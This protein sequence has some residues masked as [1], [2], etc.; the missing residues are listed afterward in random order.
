MANSS[1]SKS[2]IFTPVS[3]ANGGTG[4]TTLT[5]ILKGNGTSAFTAVTA[6]SGNIVGD[7]D[8]Q[9][10]T[11]K[12]ISLGSNTIYGT[13]SQFNSALSD[14]DFAT[15]AGTETLSG[16]TLVSPKIANNGSI[17]DENGNEQ[18][19]F[20]TTASA[21][22]ELTIKNAS[23]GQAPE[24]QATGNDTN[25]DLKL[26]PKGSGKI[27]PNN[28]VNFGAFTAYFTET[29][30]GN[31]GTAKTIDWTL[32]N[33]QKITLTGNCTFTFTNPPGPCSL[34]FKLAQDATG[35]RTVTWPSAVKWSGGTAPTL[36]T[37]ANKVDIISFYYDGSSYFGTYSL[38]YT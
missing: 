27:V 29:N 15:L 33:K 14:G 17:N 38:N 4:A 16:K 7:T 5:G 36:T 28:N 12:T 10:L 6:P 23:T 20:S 13:I 19:K 18:I 26:T 2:S 21:V 30:N 37:A 8:T 3:V 31:S 24:I 22:N 9:T 11:N 25:I 35:S 32:S 1:F 34:I